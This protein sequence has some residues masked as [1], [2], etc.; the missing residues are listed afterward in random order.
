MVSKPRGVGILGAGKDIPQYPDIASRRYFDHR[1]LS[2]SKQ[3]NRN[4]PTIGNSK[5][6]QICPLIL[7]Y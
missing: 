2:A 1:I 3:D 6:K 7:S 4:K 5:D